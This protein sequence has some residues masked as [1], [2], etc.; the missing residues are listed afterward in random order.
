[1]SKAPIESRQL[2]HPGLLG[3]PGEALIKR[4]RRCQAVIGTL[5]EICP[6]CMD[7]QY[8]TEELGYIEEVLHQRP[9][10]AITVA[11]D[12]KKIP[13]LVLFRNTELGWC[14]C[15]LHE[16]ADKRRR[17]HGVHFPE[18]LCAECTRIYERVSAR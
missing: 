9:L 4:C 16:L 11:H 1:M 6:A 14:G 5:T 12:R 7:K 2:V 3:H 10:Y 15:E 8:L 17:M 13:H 18:D